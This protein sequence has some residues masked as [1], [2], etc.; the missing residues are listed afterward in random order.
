MFFS[1][2]TQQMRIKVVARFERQMIWT[3]ID[4]VW[5]NDLRSCRFFS[6]I[7]LWNS[8]HMF[9]CSWIWIFL[10]AH[11][12]LFGRRPRGLS[13]AIDVLLSSLV[14]VAA[15]V[16]FLFPS[17]VLNPSDTQISTENLAIDTWACSLTQKRKKKNGTTNSQTYIIILKVTRYFTII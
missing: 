13:P 1:Y 5:G 16:T 2:R 8:K 15:A 9:E 17:P 6:L 7:S 11:E 4:F 10:C 14:V 12:M 3:N